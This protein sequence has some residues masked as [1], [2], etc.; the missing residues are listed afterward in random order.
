MCQEIYMNGLMPQQTFSPHAHDQKVLLSHLLSLQIDINSFYQI[1]ANAQLPHAPAA[2]QV[3]NCFNP[4]YT[5]F[6]LRQSNLGRLETI[7]AP[8]KI[9]KGE[10]KTELCLT[11]F[12]TKS[13]NQL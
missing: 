9:N 1:A 10:F 4:L 12:D 3:S 2:L 8:K 5:A 7:M 11:N 13:S 6:C